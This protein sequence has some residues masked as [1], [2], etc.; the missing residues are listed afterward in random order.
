MITLGAMFYMWR[1]DRDMQWACFRNAEIAPKF[2]IDGH[3]RHSVTPEQVRI[4]YRIFK[5]Y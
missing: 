5:L 3:G 4:P 1:A 2:N